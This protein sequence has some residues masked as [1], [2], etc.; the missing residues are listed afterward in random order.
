MSDVVRLLLGGAI[1]LFFLDRALRW[2]EARGWIYYRKTKPGRSAVAY[3]ILET[4]SVFNP[5][6]KAVQE[7][8]IEE[9]KRE[10]E[11]GDPVG[12]QRGPDA[13]TG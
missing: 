2:L 6:F 4:G 9:E 7:I 3:H 11:S 12:P 13:E 5:S 1:G 10:D 8:Q